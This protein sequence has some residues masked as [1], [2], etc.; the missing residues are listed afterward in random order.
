[1]QSEFARDL[2]DQDRPIEQALVERPGK[3][4][5]LRIQPMIL[6]ARQYRAWKDVRWTLEC[7]DAAEAAA[8]RDA[9]RVFFTALAERGPAAVSAALLAPDGKERVA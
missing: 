2:A 4:L 9:M 3:P 8:V 5:K 6:H 1:M 7:A